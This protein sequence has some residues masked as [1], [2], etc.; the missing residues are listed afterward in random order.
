[1]E[2]PESGDAGDGC[3]YVDD[4]TLSTNIKFLAVMVPASLWHCPR[5]LKTGLSE[6]GGML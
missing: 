1:M 5:I 6:H 4:F 2:K 3:R